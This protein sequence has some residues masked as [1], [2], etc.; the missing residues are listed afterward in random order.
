MA[1]YLELAKLRLSGLAVFAVLAGLGLG[2]EG[3]PSWWLTLATLV[4]T[5]AVAVGAR[6]RAPATAAVLRV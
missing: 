2:A 3:L 4:G 6:P 5:V 1:A